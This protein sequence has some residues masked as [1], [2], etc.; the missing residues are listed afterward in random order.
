MASKLSRVEEYLTRLE[1]ISERFPE[2]VE[3]I[4][5]PFLSY[6]QLYPPRVFP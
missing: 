1:K 3:F 6:T 4:E 5:I 2:P